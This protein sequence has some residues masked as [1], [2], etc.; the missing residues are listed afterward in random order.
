MNKS[1][2]TDG[3]NQGYVKYGKDNKE[4][5]LTSN[6]PEILKQAEKTTKVKYPKG[7]L[8]VGFIT[9]VTIAAFLVCYFYDRDYENPEI[10]MPWS[11]CLSVAFGIGFFLNLL[12]LVWRQHFGL[13]S[14][15]AGRQMLD[16]ITFRQFREKRDWVIRSYAWNNVKTFADYQEYLVNKKKHT[17]KVFYISLS[18][19]TVLFFISIILSFTVRT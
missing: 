17:T 7:Y 2:K 9:T 19:Y 6:S 14:K 13:K 8:T 3:I 4:S 11:D 18:S 1:K 10:N 15:F 16:V 5:L 12:W